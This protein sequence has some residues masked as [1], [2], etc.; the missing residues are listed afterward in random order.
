MRDWNVWQLSYLKEFF[1]VRMPTLDYLLEEDG[2]LL[3]TGYKIE[4]LK[5]RGTGRLALNGENLAF[6]S[7]DGAASAFSLAD[8]KGI[9]MHNKENLEF[10]FNDTLYNFSSDNKRASLYKWYNAVVAMREHKGLR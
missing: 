10:Y 2:I 6:I 1:S 8:I 5:R 3:H 4:P 9:N 7:G